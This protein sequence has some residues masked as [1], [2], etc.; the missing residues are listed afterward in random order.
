MSDGAS[1]R[2]PTTVMAAVMLL[3]GTFTLVLTPSEAHGALVSASIEA[4]DDD[5]VYGKNETYNAMLTSA[6]MV[7]VEV[8]G[9]TWV[10]VDLWIESANGWTTFL[11]PSQL[12]WYPGDE[13]TQYF[14]WGLKVPPQTN[15]TLH[16]TVTIDGRARSNA[17]ISLAIEEEVIKVE[18]VGRALMEENKMGE[19]AVQGDRAMMHGLPGYLILVATI[20]SISVVVLLYVRWKLK[21]KRK[22]KLIKD[23]L[24]RSD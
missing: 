2:N 12:E 4:L 24:S 1:I 17:V 9:P 15:E 11:D 8:T 14:N 5:I 21:E 7:H 10:V 16:D 20:A 19:S 23:T 13:S 6:G 22:L 3:M 18:V